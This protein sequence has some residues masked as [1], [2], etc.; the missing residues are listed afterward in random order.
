MVRWRFVCPWA[1][2]AL[3]VGREEKRGRRRKVGGACV[4]QSGYSTVGYFLDARG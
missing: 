3:R 1:A 4:S 2:I